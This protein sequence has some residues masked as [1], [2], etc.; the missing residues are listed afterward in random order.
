MMKDKYHINCGSRH[1]WNESHIEMYT[2]CTK[3]IA[4]SSPQIM[5]AICN[6]QEVAKGNYSDLDLWDYWLTLQNMD[7]DQR[8]LESKE[9]DKSTVKLK[10]MAG[11]DTS[12]CDKDQFETECEHG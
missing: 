8:V 4:D 11:Q 2:D 3:D 1:A 10:M 7:N 6:I 9:L 12:R 5:N